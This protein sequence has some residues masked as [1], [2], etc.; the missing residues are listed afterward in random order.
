M[1]SISDQFCF[2]QKRIDL[3]FQLSK[4]CCCLKN[5]EEKAGIVLTRTRVKKQP[6]REDIKKIFSMGEIKSRNFQAMWK[7]RNPQNFSLLCI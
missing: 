4:G 6:L 3:L 7:N 2:S 1:K 5:L